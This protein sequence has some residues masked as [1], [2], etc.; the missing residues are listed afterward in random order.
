MTKIHRITKK[1]KEGKIA[2]KKGEKDGDSQPEYEQGIALLFENIASNKICVL[3]LFKENNTKY[4]LSVLREISERIR[5]DLHGSEFTK[6][7]LD[8]EGNIC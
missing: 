6:L 2:S 8:R 1:V 4:T 5:N 3:Y 7:T